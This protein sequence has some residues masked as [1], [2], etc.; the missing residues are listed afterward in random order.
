MEGNYKTYVNLYSTNPLALSKQQQ[1][2]DREKRRHLS[3]KFS[4]TPLSEFVWSGVIYGQSRQT[5]DAVKRMLLKMEAT[6]DQCFFHP[7]WCLNSGRWQ[8]AVGLCSTAAE[9]ALALMILEAC[10]KPLLFN[11]VWHES[12]GKLLSAFNCYI[13]S[14]LM[15]HFQCTVYSV[16]QRVIQLTVQGPNNWP[17]Q[18][19]QNVE[20]IYYED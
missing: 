11:S 1:N 12:L 20:Q 6:I 8:K 13:L 14:Q 15:H 16:E 17:P 7:N 10:M 4:L 9:F 19:C 5:V 3:Y 18:Q 2:D